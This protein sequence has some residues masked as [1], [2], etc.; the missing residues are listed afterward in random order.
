M[1]MHVTYIG[2]NDCRSSLPRSDG[3]DIVRPLNTAAEQFHGNYITRNFGRESEQTLLIKH[4]FHVCVRCSNERC[5]IESTKCCFVSD[6]RIGSSAE[7]YLNQSP[8][9][10]I[11][12]T[13]LT[14][15]V[16]CVL[17]VKVETVG[18]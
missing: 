7:R 10:L 5:K 8:L 15:T 17:K 18:N 1:K 14:R 3:D 12:R 16:Q 11:C 2:R 13:A 6:A 9:S 4:C